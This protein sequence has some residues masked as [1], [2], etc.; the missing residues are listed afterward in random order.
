MF[1]VTTLF[2]LVELYLPRSSRNTF[3][4]TE[5]CSSF[6]D[7][8]KPIKPIFCAKVYQKLLYKMKLNY[9]TNY[10]LVA[11]FLKPFYLFVTV[12]FRLKQQNTNN[13]SNGVTKWIPQRLDKGAPGSE[14][15]PHCQQNYG[16][17][18]IITPWAGNPR[19]SFLASNIGLP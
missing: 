16:T 10:N 18:A 2:L 5:N 9:K 6:I 14:G 7:S 15:T 11:H 19:I 1:R 3:P 13:F 4:E 12:S 17:F 8:Q